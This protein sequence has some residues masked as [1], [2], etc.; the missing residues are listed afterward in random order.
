MVGAGVAISLVLKERILQRD[1]NKVKGHLMSTH[2]TKG[3]KV[4]NGISIVASQ[5]ASDL[6]AALKRQLMGL[7]DATMRETWLPM[8][9]RVLVVQ[10]FPT[11]RR[12]VDR[13]QY[14]DDAL[15]SYVDNLLEEAE[16][17]GVFCKKSAAI[18]SLRGLKADLVSSEMAA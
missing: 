4:V 3:T 15:R 6:K 10:E 2:A 12:L 17:F 5:Q 14:R 8:G 18:R 16:P 7:L 1:L 11:M 13:G 9:F